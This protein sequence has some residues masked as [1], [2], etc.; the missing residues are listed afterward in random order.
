MVFTVSCSVHPTPAIQLSM[1]VMML[2]DDVSFE[3]VIFKLFAVYVDVVTDIII[4][5]YSAPLCN[6]CIYTA[7]YCT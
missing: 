7:I 3:I 5:F 2:L 4:L 6:L 1:A